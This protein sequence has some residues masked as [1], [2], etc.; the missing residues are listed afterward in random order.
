MGGKDLSLQR[1]KQRERDIELYIGSLSDFLRK[2]SRRILKRIAE[3]D[4]TVQET[5]AILGSLESE[6]VANGLEDEIRQLGFI[7]A[8]ELV[9]IRKAYS[10]ISKEFTLSEVDLDVIEA[11]AQFDTQRIGTFVDDYLGGLKTSMT[12]SIFL[13]ETPDLDALQEVNESTLAYRARTELNTAL[14]ALN[15]TVTLKKADDLNIE[16]FE[17]VGPLDK[18]TREFCAARVGK[19]FTR[20]EIATWDNGQGLPADVYL[21]GYNC[22]HQLVAVRDEEGRERREQQR[23]DQNEERI[24]KAA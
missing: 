24:L 10:G 23:K 15:R 11:L 13:G 20:A 19:V 17:Y 9:A 6:L 8:D 2:N 4:A 14:S 21:G 22:R 18:K 1:I 12:S 5:L 7:H 16:Y 3:G